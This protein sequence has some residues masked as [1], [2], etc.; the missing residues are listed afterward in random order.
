MTYTCA[1]C[2]ISPVTGER[3][4]FGLDGFGRP[5]GRP[6]EASEARGVKFFGL[7]ILCS[8]ILGILANL[9]AG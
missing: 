4:P 8:P 9:L 5:A 6:L 2:P 1:P 3:A 7:A